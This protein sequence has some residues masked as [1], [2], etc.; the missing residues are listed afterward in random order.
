MCWV[1]FHKTTEKPPV[2]LYTN[3]RTRSTITESITPTSF[4][5][6]D[7]DTVEYEE[8]SSRPTSLGPYSRGLGSGFSG[9][10]D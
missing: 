6:S 5:K 7:V 4:Q 2:V 10:R 8:S 9:L 3:L 1:Y